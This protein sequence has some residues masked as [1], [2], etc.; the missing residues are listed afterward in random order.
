MLKVTK[1]MAA[2]LVAMV[3][4]FALIPVH[5]ELP[6]LTGFWEDPDAADRAEFVIL[7][8]YD[9]WTDERMG[10]EPAGNYVVTLTWASGADT[11]DTYRMVAHEDGDGI[12]YDN[13]LY[14]SVTGE[15]TELL[16]DMGKGR[17]TLTEKGTLLWQDSYYEGASEIELHCVS[18]PVP[19]TEELAE[20]FY[21]PIAALTE[22]TAGSSLQFAQT[23]YGVFRFC[24]ENQ[25][26]L[27][28]NSEM[29]G[30]MRAA[31][32]SLTEEERAVFDAREPE[33]TAAAL[34]L[35]EED[36]EVD[37]VYA[38]AG[39]L[40]HLQALREDA[41]VRFGVADFL[42]CVMTLENSEEP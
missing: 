31:L 32:D 18:A 12:A 40:D 15:E 34:K 36:A 30:N 25:L 28:S 21:R 16:E 8:D 17:F 11:V 13:G 41:T 38:D 7:H 19:G 14:V 26:W 4:L 5:A 29:S 20:N 33:V 22:G 37:S 23:V 3:C 1:K 24:M 6:D 9:M 27:V 39:V 2:L 10:E 42:S 35:L